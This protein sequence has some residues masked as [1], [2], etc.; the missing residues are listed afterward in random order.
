MAGRT[1]LTAISAG[2]ILAG[3]IGGYMVVS[4]HRADSASDDAARS[5]AQQL[6]TAWSKGKVQDARFLGSSGTAAAENFKTATG[7]LGDGPVAVK[8]GTVNRDGKTAVADLQ[9]RWTLR[10]GKTFAWT[11]PVS[12]QEAEGGWGVKVRENVSLWHPKLP[13]NGSFAVQSAS[14]ER[15][16]IL[17]KDNAKI[18]ANRPVYDIALDPAKATAAS[19]TSLQGIVGQSDLAAQLKAAQGKKS[20]AL[21][22]VITYREADY[23]AKENQ[24]SALTGVVVNKRQQP[25]AATRTFGQPLLG[26]VGPV[27]AEMV[28]KDRK[29]RPDTVVGRSGLQAQFN[30]LL[31]PTGGLTVTVAG[32]SDE[33]LHGTKSTAG[34]DLRTTLDPSVQTAAEKALAAAG[35]SSPA[36]IVALDV[37]SGN[38]L[39]VANS[40]SSGINRA[41]TGRYQ[42]GS[43]LKVSTTYALLTDGFASSEKVPCPPSIVVDG[44]RIGNFEQETLPDDSTFVDSFAHSCNTA[45]VQAGTQLS[46]NA[47][48]KAAADLGI[49]VDWTKQLGVSA[50]TGSVPPTEGEVDHAATTFGQARTLA[51]PMSI[52]VMTG[53]VARGSMIPPQLIVGAGG[54]R[55]PKPLNTT[56][57][58]DIKT[59]MRKVVTEGTGKVLNGTPGGDVY[60]KTGT[61]EFTG[62]GGKPVSRAWLTG[63]QGDVAFAVLVEDVPRGSGG[64][65]KAAPVA[66]D[67][68]SELAKR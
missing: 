9:V 40:P 2:V 15:G 53:S 13:A 18:M 43:T 50:F 4:D 64:G 66:K 54:E 1:V 42:P 24:I 38:V 51:S 32:N 46:P 68:L 30:S 58:A 28:E 20:T 41:L 26:T 52:A 21:I 8:V 61:A 47:M 7:A 22:S 35:D 19:A 27:T 31:A 39:A 33:V 3:G 44:R 63:W 49:G 17:G 37:K 56:A 45:F 60:A 23:Q 16:E 57:T 48:T 62:E 59:M 12:L 5:A 25:L 36:A 14:A 11:D 10:D 29:L 65:D 55:T 6:A 67:F 34:K